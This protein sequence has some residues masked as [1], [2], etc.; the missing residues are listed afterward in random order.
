MEEYKMKKKIALWL[1]GVI[2]ILTFTL[3]I[4]WDIIA[5]SLLSL[6]LSHLFILILLQ[7]LGLALL[8]YQWYYIINIKKPLLSFKDVFRIY[9]AGA[10]V[11]SI[12]PSV[13]LGGEAAKVV[14]FRKHTSLSYRELTGILI[15]QKYIVLLPFCIICLPVFLLG[16]RILNPPA[17]VYYSLLT[18]FLLLGLSLLLI[19][20]RVKGKKMKNKK[21][22]SISDRA[23][24]I[25][26]VYFM[27]KKIIDFFDQALRYASE[28]LTHRDL[29]RLSVLSLLIWLLYPL[30]VYLVA[31]NLNQSSSLLLVALATYTA[32]L[33]SMLPLLPGGLGS[34]ET[35]MAFMLALGGLTTVEGMSIALIARSITFWLPLLLSAIFTLQLGVSFHSIQASKGEAA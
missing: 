34:F 15:L 3:Y 9:M 17:P 24:L 29:I 16:T 14:L 4:G 11:E 27:I 2:I 21:K 18:L 35:S 5:Q 28:L 10:F 25:E 8:A 19:Y 6:P 30:K 26:K 23:S 31:I 1:T 20:L 33:I 7:L 22:P 32:Y 12:T 13:K